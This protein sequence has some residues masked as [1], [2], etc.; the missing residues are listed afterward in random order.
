MNLTK[1]IDEK[2]V[3]PSKDMHPT[4]CISPCAKFVGG[5]KVGLCDPTP[6]IAP[7]IG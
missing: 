7:S 3:A 2:S 4:K 6:I 5:G 1:A